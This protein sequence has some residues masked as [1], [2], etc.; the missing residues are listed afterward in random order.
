[1]ATDA[2]ALAAP[3]T[4]NKNTAKAAWRRW[5]PKPAHLLVLPYFV[6]LIL[7]GVGPGI[8]ALIISFAD[9]EM[10]KPKFFQAGIS[11]YIAAYTDFR[12]MSAMKNVGLFLLISI[13]VGI[14]GV[15]FLSLLLHA[16]RGR[17]S[18]SMRTIYFVPGAVAGPTAVLLA[19]FMFD[20]NISPFAP[21]LHAMGFELVNDV[22]VERHLPMI[23]T[24]LG[25]FAGAGA[26]IAIFYGALNNISE[27]VVEAAIIDGC[28]AWGLAW[29]IKRPLIMPFVIYMVILVFAGNVQLFAEPQLI[30]AANVAGI[31]K[32][33][34]PNQLGYAF[35]F[36][37]GDF[38][39]SAALSL[40][41]VAI[42][43]L[44]AVLILSTTNIFKAE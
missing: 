35:A 16:R 3:P 24:L 14:A 21:L 44:G 26:W 9:F 23:F 27:E 11:N 30:G 22:I 38:G 4:T 42:G 19:I 43:L 17:F 8:Y 2:G 1:M 20:P 41:M 13:P 15:L 12:F 29:L 18:D 40:L 32:Y 34:S 28:N 37:Q 31:S 7:F 10:G 36:E 33:W 39:S 6:L 25:F 5:G